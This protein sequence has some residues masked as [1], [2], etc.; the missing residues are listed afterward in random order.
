MRR[1]KLRLVCLTKLHKKGY[2]AKKGYLQK[3]KLL[4]NTSSS[5]SCRAGSGEM[6]RFRKRNI[7]VQITYLCN[8]NRNTEPVSVVRSMISLSTRRLTHNV[9]L[10]PLRAAI[11]IIF[12]SLPLSTVLLFSRFYTGSP[13]L[14]STVAHSSRGNR[15]CCRQI[16]VLERFVT[17]LDTFL[18]LY[19]EAALE[20]NF[21]LH[22]QSF[23][24]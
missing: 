18:T 5:F 20:V 6:Q 16:L 9:A 7:S 1:N 10:A 23:A 24:S 19:L 22:L 12:V 21:L 11:K 2:M 15:S 8:R 17:L 3:Y 4:L 14:G 13:Q